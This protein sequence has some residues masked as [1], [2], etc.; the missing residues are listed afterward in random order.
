MDA[1]V[2]DMAHI[3]WD[4]VKWNVCH[5]LWK[6]LEVWIGSRAAL[7]NEWVAQSAVGGD[8]GG[9]RCTRWLHP[10]PYHFTGGVGYIP[11]HSIHDHCRTSDDKKSD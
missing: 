11:L 3:I 9:A 8:V 5:M 10:R 7:A 2:M 4:W 6:S 1:F